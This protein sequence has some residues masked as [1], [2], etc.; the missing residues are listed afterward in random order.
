MTDWSRVGRSSRT[1]GHTY[2]RNIA[3]ILNKLVGSN[4][5]RTPASGGHAIEGDLYEA[6]M[7]ATKWSKVVFYCRTGWAWSWDDV[8]RNNDKCGPLSWVKET[9]A[10][11]IWVFRTKPGINYVCFHKNRWVAPSRIVLFCIQT[12]NFMIMKLEHFATCEAKGFI[13]LEPVQIGD[14]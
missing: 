12:K 2:E 6:P 14:E 11:P 5:V 13:S 9:G 3:K 7:K 1:K 8:F 10:N 4:F